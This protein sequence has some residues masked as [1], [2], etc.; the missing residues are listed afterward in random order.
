MLDQSRFL[1]FNKLYRLT[2]NRVWQLLFTIRRT[3]YC[4]FKC[5]QRNFTNI[6]R[7][8]G[9]DFF[10]TWKT[11]I[12]AI[13]NVSKFCG[14]VPS[15]KLNWPPKSCMPRSAN[16]KMNRNSRNKSDIIE[17]M[18]FNNDI[19]RFRKDDQYLK[20]RKTQFIIIYSSS[21]SFFG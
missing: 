11:V 7:N 2:R 20:G 4:F 16:I 14:G 19:T 5:K 15:S 1:L 12:K 6:R 3:K 21:A 9:F 18:E 10:Y 13:G 17:R 8:I